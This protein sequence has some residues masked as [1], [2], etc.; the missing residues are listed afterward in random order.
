MS[1][2]PLRE[3]SGNW[4]FLLPSSAEEGRALARPAPGW[5]DRRLKKAPTTRFVPKILE[6]GTKRLNDGSRN[7]P[8][9]TPV[10]LHGTSPPCFRR[11]AIKTSNLEARSLS[12]GEMK[13]GS[14]RSVSVGP[15]A[16]IIGRQGQLESQIVVLSRLPSISLRA[17]QISFGVVRLPKTR[18]FPIHVL[19]HVV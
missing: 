11:G 9:T 4:T 5:C 16:D 17:T 14:C 2:S 7:F 1:S 10:L 18:L 13:R 19:T 12:K 8:Q 6:L 15:G 3:A